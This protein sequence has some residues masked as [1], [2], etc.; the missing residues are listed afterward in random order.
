MQYVPLADID[1]SVLSRTDST[2]YCPVKGEA[3][4]Y[5]V[6]TA[7]G[8]VVDAGRACDGPYD[9]VAPIA[10]HVA[11]WPGR[12]DVLID[13]PAAN[14]TH[15]STEEACW[16]PAPRAQRRSPAGPV[17]GTG[18]SPLPTSCSTPRACRRSASTGGAVPEGRVP[19]LLHDDLALSGRMERDRASAPAA[20]AVA[21]SLLDASVA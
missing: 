21:A 1:A 4:Y 15:L 14:Q 9:A 3:S 6:T 8:S 20:R 5:S 11:F 2:S 10:T 7:D 18:C 17:R 16:P 13:Q 12:A 19:Q